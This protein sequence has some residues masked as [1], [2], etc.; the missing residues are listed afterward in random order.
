M[1]C[2]APWTYNDGLANLNSQRRRQA[3]RYRHANPNCAGCEGLG[4][5]TNRPLCQCFGGFFIGLS[6]GLIALRKQFKM[7]IGDVG[8]ERL[9]RASR[10]HGNFAEYVPIALI[11]LLLV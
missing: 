2:S 6:L 7:L 4:H 1:R 3:L 11:L 10:A 8:H 9:L 5:E